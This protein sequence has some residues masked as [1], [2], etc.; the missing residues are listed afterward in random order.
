MILFRELTLR[1]DGLGALRWNTTVLLTTEPDTKP[2]QYYS[3]Y[4]LFIVF[5]R[6]ISLLFSP[7][8]IF[9]CGSRKN[10]TR[11]ELIGQVSHLRTTNLFW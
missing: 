7:F 4:R 3:F 8:S 1:R 10:I 2:L 6:D 5:D 11:K 9:S